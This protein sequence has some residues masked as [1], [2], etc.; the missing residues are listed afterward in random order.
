MNKA[1]Q[2]DQ[3]LLLEL[4]GPQTPPPN[5][6][7][8]PS[9]CVLVKDDIFFDQTAIPAFVEQ[10]SNPFRGCPQTT[11][12]PGLL[13]W[14]HALSET[15]CQSILAHIKDNNWFRPQV[16]INQVVRF[17][18][19]PS[20]LDLLCQLGKQLVCPT[21]M[22]RTPLFDHMIANHY[23]PNDG[24]V[25]HVDL[26]NRFADGIVVASISGSCIMEF[27]PSDNANQNHQPKVN[28]NHHQP[29]GTIEMFL[30]QGDLIGLS[31]EAR[32][33]WKHGIP[34]RLNDQWQG[35]IYPRTER[36]SVTLRRLLPQ[37]DE[38]F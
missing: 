28:Q 35:E 30:Q 21:L 20:F 12:I 31:G 22:S 26:V 16:G 33:D 5:A 13:L 32:W 11:S 19:I 17:G 10:G 15:E 24:L 23:Y 29:A 7:S 37:T 8:E 38:S 4:F 6:T 14:K 36:I 3:D 1:E 25:S 18:T 9:D 2:D 27:S 34:V